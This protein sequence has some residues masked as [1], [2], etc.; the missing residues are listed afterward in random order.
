MAND[1]AR[2]ELR[3]KEIVMQRV[4]KSPAA[5]ADQSAMRNGGKTCHR[6]EQSPGVELLAVRR[7]MSVQGISSAV[8]Q[9]HQCVANSVGGKS[10]PIVGSEDLAARKKNHLDKVL[11]S[12]RQNFHARA[13]R[14]A[15]QQRTTFSFDE[16]AARALEFV[17]VR[18][19][20]RQ[21]QQSVRAKG[22]PV[23]ASVVRVSEAGEQ[24]GSFVGSSITVGIFEGDQVRRIGDKQ[25]S[26]APREAHRKDQLIDKN[27]A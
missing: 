12:T 3:G 26:I 15:T 23:K 14:F 4:R 1:F 19:A 2:V 11:E 25:L 9:V 18:L 22:Q 20:H 10:K 27:P 13:V 24:D 16:R 5:V 7:R 17:S 8:H 21:I 6:R